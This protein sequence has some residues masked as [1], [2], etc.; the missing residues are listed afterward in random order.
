MH[1]LS[2]AQSLIGEAERVLQGEPSRRP[3]EITVAVGRLSGVERLPLETCFPLAAEGTR[4]EGCRLN[5]EE[6]PV[7][8]S[9]ASCGA[10]TRPDFPDLSC[11]ACASRDTQVEQGYEL[12]LKTM[13]VECD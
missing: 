4:L 5:I 3:R 8:V 6:L 1:E 11:A 12:I 2:I 7:E 9:C 10:R 13:E